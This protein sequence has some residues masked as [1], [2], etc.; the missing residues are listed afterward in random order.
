MFLKENMDIKDGV[1]TSS[2]E[3]LRSPVRVREHD[4]I[5]PKGGK[6]RS[7]TKEHRRGL[8][9]KRPNFMREDP[10]S[11]TWGWHH[12]NNAF[13]GGKVQN[14]KRTYVCEG[15]TEP[16][17]NG[18]RPVGPGWPACPVPTSGQPPIS[19]VWRWC[20]P[21]YVEVPPFAGREPFAWEAIHKL[22]R[23]KRR[24]II[25]KEDRSTRRKTPSEA[26][27]WSTVLFLALWW[28][29]FSFVHGL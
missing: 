22:V 25:R 14:V 9:R 3:Q 18:P 17:R 2:K 28:V 1:T 13:G 23:E 11:W 16:G 5:T 15:A 26:S 8:K 27:P 10:P 7:V 24:E 20:N 4:E 6:D 29:I 19:C 12:Q 21:K